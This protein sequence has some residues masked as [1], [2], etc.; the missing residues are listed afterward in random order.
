MQ[1]IK[2]S[3]RLPKKNLL[4]EVKSDYFPDGKNYA[5]LVDTEHGTNWVYFVSNLTDNRTIIIPFERIS[6]WRWVETEEMSNEFEEVKK[7]I[8]EYYNKADCGLFFC[9]N[10]TNDIMGTIY[11]KNGIQIDICYRYKYFE[12]FGLD[13]PQQLE[14]KIFYDVLEQEHRKENMNE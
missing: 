5:C 4:V 6:E 14:L 11:Y 1:W 10:M 12:V 8:K 7:I 3:E 13:L 2:T 9:R